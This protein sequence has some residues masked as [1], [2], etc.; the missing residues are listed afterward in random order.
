MTDWKGPC[1]FKAHAASH[2][3]QK[4]MMYLIK[5]DSILN[6]KCDW[7]GQQRRRFVLVIVTTEF[8]L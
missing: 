1:S 3:S 5:R 7:H 4:G 8:Y 6:V 2:I